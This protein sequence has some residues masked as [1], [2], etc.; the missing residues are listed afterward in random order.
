MATLNKRNE[1]I[2]TCRHRRK[3][4]IRY[5]Q[6]RHI[7]KLVNLAR[8]IGAAQVLQVRALFISTVFIT[9]AYCFNRYV[10]HCHHAILLMQ[11]QRFSV[12]WSLTEEW[13]T[14]GHCLIHLNKLACKIWSCL[15]N[16]QFQPE[17]SYV[18]FPPNPSIILCCID[19]HSKIIRQLSRVRLK[20]A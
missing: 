10:N 3:F 16:V 1:L 13:V 9:R 15:G 8:A 14:F 20:P 4:I 2:S 19:F 6:T 11:I 12:K 18:L 17:I 5:S 7:S